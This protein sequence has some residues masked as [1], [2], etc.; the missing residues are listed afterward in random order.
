MSSIGQLSN[1]EQHPYHHAL[2]RLRRALNKPPSFEEFVKGGVTE[3]ILIAN[4]VHSRQFRHRFATLTVSVGAKGQ[5]LKKPRVKAHPLV[6]WVAD[7][8]Q[9]HDIAPNANYG[10][11]S[12]ATAPGEREDEVRRAFTLLREAL[13]DRVRRHALAAIGTH[14][15]SIWNPAERALPADEPPVILISHH[16]NSAREVGVMACSLVPPGTPYFADDNSVRRPNGVSLGV[17]HGI[18]IHG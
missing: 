2:K 6:R 3:I 7:E 1:H 16:G 8:L 4:E 13:N 10:F 14:L 15:L 12:I 9:K 18:C 5:P 11:K 17:A